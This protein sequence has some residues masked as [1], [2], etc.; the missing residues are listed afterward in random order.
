[1]MKAHKGLELGSGIEPR[2]H[3]ITQA[4]INVYSRY[5]FHGKDTKNIH[6]DD[7]VAR[8]AGMPR[9]LAQGRYPVGYLSE[10]LL[11]LFERGWIQE[12]KLDVSF[13][14]PIFPGDTITVRGVVRNKVPEGRFIRIT[15]D[16]WLENQNGEK[17]T[18]G[19]ASGLV[20]S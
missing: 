18:A 1:M 13:V 6:T 4:K 9:A 5:V 14:K 8:K 17:A 20:A 15:L 19:T 12:G 11:D 7:E 2:V 3:E 16:I 10:Y